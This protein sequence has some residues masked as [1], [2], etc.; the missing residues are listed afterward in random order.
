MKFLTKGLEPEKR[1]NLLL[2]LTKIGSE[3][4]KSALVDHLTKGLAENDAAMLNDVSQQNFNRALK[5]LNGVA[6]VVEQI[7]E[8][9]WNDKVNA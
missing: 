7:K 9:D 5:R 1:I 3:N 2:Q 8:M 6:G 4:I